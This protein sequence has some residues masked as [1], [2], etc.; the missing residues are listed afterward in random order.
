MC[1][2]PHETSGCGWVS[3]KKAV[4]RH[5]HD[6]IPESFFHARNAAHNAAIIQQGAVWGSNAGSMYG[7]SLIG[8]PAWGHLSEASSVIHPGDS[9]SHSS[10]TEY[11]AWWATRAPPHP[12]AHTRTCLEQGKPHQSPLGRPRDTPQPKLTTTSSPQV[13]AAAERI[14]Q[15]PNGTRRLEMHPTPYKLVRP[16]STSTIHGIPTK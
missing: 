12:L 5:R 1:H 2:E 15:V 16:V 3:E 13:R 14:P 9:P 6:A 7:N 8:S 11:P 10:R 4:V